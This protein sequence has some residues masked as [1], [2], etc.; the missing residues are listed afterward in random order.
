MPM[1]RAP[2]LWSVLGLAV[3]TSAA[4]L[5]PTML[6]AQAATPDS[7][8]FTA[9]D[10]VRIHYLTSGEEGSWVVLV[11][12]FTDSAR[13]MW[14]TTGIA[15][16][17]AANHRV[18]ALDNRNHGESDRPEPNGVGRAEDVIELMDHLG[19]E[20]AHIHGYSMGGAITRALLATYPERFITAGFGGSGI[21]EE[22]ETLNEIAAG[23]DRQGPA[24]EG[25][26]AAAFSNLRAR[27]AAAPARP[28]APGGGLAVFSRPIDLTSVTVPVLAIN[29][30]FDAPYAKTMRMW[31]ELGTFQNVVLPGHNHMSAIAVGGPMPREYVDATVG[32][33]AAYDER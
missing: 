13:R 31:R 11:H 7:Y 23:F 14:F 16:E 25:A 6:D 22:D 18:V 20:R 2:I 28:G 15:P 9:S 33:I 1:Q 12:G 10:G 4:A 5:F 27:A 29:G 17:L 26:Q 30:E 21:R 19:I 24:P 3:A 32:F 8:F